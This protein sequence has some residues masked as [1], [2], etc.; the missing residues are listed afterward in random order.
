MSIPLPPSALFNSPLLWAFPTGTFVPRLPLWFLLVLAAPQNLQ[1]LLKCDS[2][3]K[4]P[5]EGQVQWHDGAL[6][7]MISTEQVDLH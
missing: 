5:G 7:C 3:N 4:I 6:S 2:S 1:I